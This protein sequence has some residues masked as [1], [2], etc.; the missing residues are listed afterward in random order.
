MNTTET[1]KIAEFSIVRVLDAPRELVWRAWTNAE[2]LAKWW[3]PV[4]FQNE[5]VGFDFR[6]GGV[7]HYKMTTD[8]GNVMWGKFVYREID[9][10]Q[11][12]VYVSSFSDENAGVTRAPFAENFPL[13]VLNTLTFEENDGK[14]TLTLRG[15][16]FNA[17]EEE[18][19]FF[20]SMH[21]SMRGGF[22]GTLDALTEHLAQAQA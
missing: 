8:D 20:A 4:I 19:A 14:T 18:I 9:E 21:D 22:G 2:H 3:G 6:I 16:P 7:F 15:V 5:V 1:A 10:P 17:S 13:E 11:K 12:L